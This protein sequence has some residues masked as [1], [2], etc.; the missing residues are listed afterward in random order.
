MSASPSER[1]NFENKRNLAKT[2]LKRIKAGEE[3]AALRLTWNHPRF[4]GKS[5]QDVFSAVPTLADCQLTIAKESGFESWPRLKN[6]VEQLDTDPNGPIAR[7]E[8]AVRCLIHGDARELA[9]ALH[10][11]PQ[12]ATVRSPRSHRCVL[13][14]YVAANGVENEHQ[15]TPA[16]IV[17]IAQLLFRCGA[18]AVVDATADIYGGGPGSTPLVG[19]VTSCHPAEAGAQAELVRVFCAAGANVNGIEEDGL[20]LACALA[21]RYPAAA[22]A[23]KS[24]GARLDNLVFAAALGKETLVADMLRQPESSWKN[25][26]NPFPGQKSPLDTP[27]TIAE[28]AFIY[29]CMSG[30]LATAQAL[31]AHGVNINA[32]PNRGAT[33]LHESAYQG[34]L[35]MVRFL[36]ANGAD[37][38][39]C[40]QQWKSTP[41]QWAAWNDH[42]GVARECS[43]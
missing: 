1:P 40:D 16:N 5:A 11:H 17:E 35:A 36:L 34:N 42:T 12:L 7:F 38:T 28:Q 3:Y 23:L 31:L 33:A 41:A 43:P 22:E 15:K 6:Y 10:T 27:Q 32:A 9:A 29:A 37:R 25:F 13:L 18:D 20:P 24:C 2:L 39:L 4:K 26:P 14:H 19:L 21:F 30:Q 8:H